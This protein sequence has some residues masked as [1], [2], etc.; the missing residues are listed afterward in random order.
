MPNPSDLIT[1]VGGETSNSYVTLDQCAAYRDLNV[2]NATAFDN[3]TPDNRIRALVLATNRLDRENWQGSKAS[4][5][6]RLAWPRASVLKPDGVGFGSDD[7]IPG[8]GALLAPRTGY[9]IYGAGA[10]GE[11][12]PSTSIPQQIKDAQCELAMAYLDGFDDGEQD[13]IDQ[14]ST[15]GVMVKFRA[16]RPSGG[17][18]PRVLLLIGA[19]IEGNM[20]RRA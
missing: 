1:T 18:P 9:G 19:M 5:K 13:A 7:F 12:F 8:A 15:D 4:S 11:V 10:F 16:Q 17:L 20:L 14:F 2:L 3:A 6:Q